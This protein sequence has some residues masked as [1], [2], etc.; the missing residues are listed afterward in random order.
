MV[1]IVPPALRDGL[2]H[3][4]DGFRYSV[5][6]E[7]DDIIEKPTLISTRFEKISKQYGVEFLPP[8]ESVNSLGY[9][10][11]R[12]L[13]NPDKAVQCFSE[14]TV[15]YPNSFNA[16]DSLAEAYM[17]KGEYDLAHDN[18]QKSLD[19]NPGN[20]GAKKWIDHLVA[21]DYDRIIEHRIENLGH[22]L[23]TGKTTPSVRIDRLLPQGY[24]GGKPCIL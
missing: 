14:N 11:L 20:R 21:K 24:F 15:N 9:Y 4:F 12:G 18:Y 7:I 19:L 6:I 1:P 8:E 17:F 5:P 3:F 23:T 2:L 16:F 22:T 10:I 13:K